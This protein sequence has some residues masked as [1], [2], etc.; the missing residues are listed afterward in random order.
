MAA[1]L[2]AIGVLGERSDLFFDGF[3]GA[4]FA[5]AAVL[6]RRRKLFLLAGSKA[7]IL[8]KCVYESSRDS[9]LQW[10]ICCI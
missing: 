3:C 10:D 8:D 4:D 2:S 9:F 5:L 1:C 6:Q 7:G